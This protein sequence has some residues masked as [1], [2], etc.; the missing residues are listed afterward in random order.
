MSDEK[1][2][3]ELEQLRAER[4]RLVGER[5]KREA[6]R[7]DATELARI[8][9]EIA[10][11]QAITKAECELGPLDRDIAA[12]QSRDHG[13][14]I[15]RRPTHAAYRQMID[16]VAASKT[17]LSVINERFAFQCLVYPEK[18]E[19]ERILKDE[20]GLLERVA[21]AAAKLAGLVV[22]EVQGK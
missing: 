7:A 17:P 16:S 12:V 5:E 2:V 15:V 22:E 18:V 11:E 20:S 21:N 1:P 19:F 9:L 14:V 4:A 8:K 13:V 10:S 3:S 6:A